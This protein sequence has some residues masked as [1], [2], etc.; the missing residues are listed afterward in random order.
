MIVWSNDN[1]G[2][3]D[4][5][6][7]R[8]LGID[9]SIVDRAMKTCSVRVTEQQW[10]TNRDQLWSFAARRE[11]ELNKSNVNWEIKITIGR[12]VCE[13]KSSLST[14]ESCL[15]KRAQ[16]RFRFDSE[17]SVDNWRDNEKSLDR[18]EIVFLRQ[19]TF[20][21]KR[22]DDLTENQRSVTYFNIN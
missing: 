15:I 21:S 5:Q 1:Q 8:F 13:W 4:L 6:S 19:L 3:W 14:E 22:K 12:F 10:L 20:Q 9:E 18:L 7:N 16:L 11:D 17:R 2:E